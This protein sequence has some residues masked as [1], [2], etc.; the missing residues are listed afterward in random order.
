MMEKGR[1][2]MEWFDCHVHVVGG[3]VEELRALAGSQRGYGYSG[4][5]FLSVEGMD[6]AAQ[7]ALGILFKCLSP[8][9]YAFGGLH[10]RF[11]YDFAAEAQRLYAMGFDGIKMIENKPTERKRLGFAQDDPRYQA[12][13]ARAADLGIPFLIHVNDPR[14]FWDP[15]LAPAW[16]VSAGYAYV[17][18]SYPPYEQI[19]AETVHMLEQHP[20]LRVCM[21]HLLF[22]SDSRER[23][24][25]LM[26]RFPNLYLDITAGTE[27]YYAFSREPE[28]WREFFLRY[29]DRILFGTDNCN[30]A[31]R[32]DREIGDTINQMERRFLTEAERFPLWDGEIQGLGLPETVCR[33][34]VWDNFRRFAAGQPRLL[35]REQ[36]LAYLEERLEESAYRLSRQERETMETVC[37]LLRSE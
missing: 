7:N 5:N 24:C 19:L 33:R 15:A 16:A 4:S 12:M 3:G 10:Y 8:S 9:H 26:E 36:A 31:S 37:R 34:I 11:S 35:Q 25:G 22:L 28:A 14:E 18:G 13:Y 23:L 20:D 30:R 32:E 1:A 29:S 27:M 2:G 17:D 21:A 6:D